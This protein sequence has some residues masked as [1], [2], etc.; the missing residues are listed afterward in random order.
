MK[1]EEYF[2]STRLNLSGFH[3]LS[4]TEIDLLKEKFI[5]ALESYAKQTA[6][7]YSE[8]II[9]NKYMSFQSE[10]YVRENPHTKPLSSADLFNEFEKFKAE[11][12]Q[13]N[14]VVK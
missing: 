2:E 10:W 11:A 13:K 12:S 4:Y 5:Y 6:I 9:K 1:T 14:N 8:W 3:E 7:E